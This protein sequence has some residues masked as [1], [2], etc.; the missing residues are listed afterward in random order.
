VSA[1]QAGEAGNGGSSVDPCSGGPL[2]TYPCDLDG[3]FRFDATTGECVA[4]TSGGCPVVPAQVFWTLAECVSTC[5]GAKPAETA[6]DDAADCAVHFVGC[7]AGCEPVD[8]EVVVAINR[9]R[10]DTLETCGAV[11]GECDT[12]S[13]TERTGEYY[14][15][16]CARRSCYVGDLRTSPDSIC[17]EDSDCIL[18]EGSKCC[19]GCDGEGFVAVSSLNWLDEVCEYA[20]PCDACVGEIPPNIAARC[21]QQSGHC[22]VVDTSAPGGD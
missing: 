12:V 20:P 18:R 4:V 2:A 16:A 15:P 1:G 14:I 5:P 6:C 7:C 3:Y 10:T 17:A 11:C 21:D 13:E 22:S 8:P 9:E 19:E